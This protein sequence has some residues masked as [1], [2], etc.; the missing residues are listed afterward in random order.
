M[1]LFLWKK[2]YELG[3]PEVDMQHRRLV[4]LINELSDAMMLRQ[5]YRAIPHVLEELVDYVQ[6]HFTSEERLMNEMNYPALTEH[7]EEHLDFT[8]KIIELKERYTRDHDVDAGELLRFMCEWLKNHIV[9]RDQ[10][11]GRYMRRVEMGLEE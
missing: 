10:E 11:F 6:L 9:A 3:S 5:G 7:R 2:S 8:G 1:A 4:G